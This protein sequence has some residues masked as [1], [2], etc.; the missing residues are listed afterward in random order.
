[1]CI[2]VS[3]PPNLFV[4][5]AC[6]F[7]L[8]VLRVFFVVCLLFLLVAAF[9][10]VGVMSYFYYCTQMT[11]IG[12]ANV[13]TIYTVLIPFSSPRAIYA[14]PPLCPLAAAAEPA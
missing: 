7:F 3:F 8:C 1:M 10:F 12:T 4:L 9:F 13:E 5:F 14:R 6:V 11:T 2:C